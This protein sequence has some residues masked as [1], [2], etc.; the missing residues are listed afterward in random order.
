MT[1]YLVS[2]LALYLSVL[3]ESQAAGRRLT[4]PG[5]LKVTR[6]VPSL[7]LQ[8]PLSSPPAIPR[9]SLSMADK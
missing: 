7:T 2:V 8:T 6:A 1:V 9:L 4:V 3:G 5:T